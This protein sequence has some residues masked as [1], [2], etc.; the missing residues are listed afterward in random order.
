[1]NRRQFGLGVLLGTFALKIPFFGA[2]I[3]TR[4]KSGW[5]LKDGDV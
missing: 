4:I 1:M 3:R 5:V 2:L